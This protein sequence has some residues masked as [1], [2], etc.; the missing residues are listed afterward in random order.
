MSPQVSVILPVYNGE[1]YLRAA[2]ASIVEQSFR[3]FELLAIDGGSTDGSLRTLG[4]FA[5]GDER[6]RVVKQSGRGLVQALNEGVAL[7]RGE[8]LARMDADDVALPNRF[9]EQV[10]FLRGHPDVAVVGSAMTLI[11]GDGRPIRE[12]SYPQQPAEIAEALKAGS[13]LA[14]P[15]VMMRRA[16]VQDMGGYREIL[17]F[18]EDYDLWLR[19]AERTSLA[20][21]P[22]RLMFYRHHDAKRGCVFAFE[23]ELHTQIA[24]L[25]AAARR[26]GQADPLVGLTSISVDDINR[27][28]LSPEQR[29]ALL[30]DL[31]QPLL[32]ASKRE[33]LARAAEVGALIGKPI[34]RSIVAQRQLE[35]AICF[36]R[37]RQIWPAARWAMRAMVVDPAQA[38]RRMASIGARVPRRL[39]SSALRLKRY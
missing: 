27:F 10:A 16:I 32:G 18:A 34:N 28:A 30:C 26:N 12:M 6:I 4:E 31:L 21:L 37:V 7:A 5:A 20:N 9:E 36:L 23:Q 8:F 19:M 17:G 15:S 24:R 2:V 39:V 38:L 1:A 14:H 13:A 11:N 33:E 3:D 22:A 35:L 29:E 25:A